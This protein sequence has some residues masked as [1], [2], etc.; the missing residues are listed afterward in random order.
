MP[1]IGGKRKKTRTHKEVNHEE[2]AI[3]GNNPKSFIFKR[4]KINHP[5]NTLIKD[6]RELMYPYTS[7]KLKESDKS[8]MKDYI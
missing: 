8:K 2:D 4:G 3:M 6:M 7:M 1:K 5:I